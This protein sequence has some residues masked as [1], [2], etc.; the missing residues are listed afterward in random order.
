MLQDLFWQ[1]NIDT[2]NNFSSV[3]QAMLD[4]APYFKGV[5]NSFSNSYTQFYYWM[6]GLVAIIVLIVI[7]NT[8][9]KHKPAT[10]T[11]AT[12]NNSGNDLYNSLLDQLD[13]NTSDRNL[14]QQIAQDTRLRHP[15]VFLLSPDMLDWSKKIWTQEKGNEP[16]TDQQ[17]K[18]IDKISYKLFG[19][20][21]SLDLSRTQYETLCQPTG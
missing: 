20:S 19:P 6:M 11:P 5:Q 12:S 8:L 18:Q 15:S 17:K 16:V 21:R 14:L 9:V 1:N 10:S 13:I 7:I 2:P 4:L 3:Q